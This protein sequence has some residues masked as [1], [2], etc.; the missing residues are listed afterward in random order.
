[1]NSEKFHVSVII[2]VFNCR[3]YIGEAIESVLS[4][5]YPPLEII[6]VEG[7][8]TDGT[9]EVV[10]KYNDRIKYIY[11]PNQGIGR[12]RNTGIR[13]SRGNY[14]AHLDADDVWLKE[15]LKLQMEAFSR[16]KDLEIVGAHMK[17]FFTPGLPPEIKN[18][19][20]CPPD[21]IPGFSAS[22]IVVKRESFLRVGWYETQWNAG[23]DLSWFIR[24]REIKLKEGMIPE[25]LVLRRLHKSNSGIRRPE[26][27]KQRLQILKEALDRRR[28]ITEG[29]T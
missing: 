9:Q 20:Y 18:K 25:V 8:S 26:L 7:G 2:P 22:A 10:K 6:V 11:Q 12:A 13:A 19:I 23:Q 1:M 21:P 4:Q 29:Q 27:G 28:K 24:A 14:L 16:D 3:E 17:S 15:K 5:T